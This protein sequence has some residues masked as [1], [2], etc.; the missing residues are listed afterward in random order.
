MAFRFSFAS[1]GKSFLG[2][3]VVMSALGL[4]IVQLKYKTFKTDMFSISWAVSAA[5]K[6]EVTSLVLSQH[7]RVQTDK[8]RDR[9]TAM[10]NRIRLLA[11]NEASMPRSLHLYL[12]SYP[13]GS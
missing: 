9:L 8:I 13:S 3:Y 5:V 2:L 7:S 1:L 4:C 11:I 12:K 10:N 6:V